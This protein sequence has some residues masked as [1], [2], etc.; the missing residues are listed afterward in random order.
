MAF[1]TGTETQTSLAVFIPQVWGQ[2]VN[3]FFKAKLACAAFFTN[4]SDEVQE[5]GNTL[6][7]PNMTEMTTNAK[8]NA[9]QVTLNSP[10]ETKIT[11]TINNWYECSFAIEDLEAAQVKRSYSTMQTYAKNA[12]YSI[13]KK[14]DIS[15]T[16]LFSTFTTSVGSSTTNLLDSDIRGA[17]ANL[18]GVDVD[19]DEC[20]WFMHP[21]VF[22]N[23]V[24]A[25]DKFSLA[26]NAP[27]QDPVGK[28]PKAYL[29]GK[30]IFLTTTIQYV[31]G[32]TGRV[33]AF[34]HPDAIHFATSPLGEGG[35]GGK[36]VGSEGIRVQSNYFPA[37]LS[38]ITTADIAY[39]SVVNR[40]YAGVA[41]LSKA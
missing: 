28:T 32:T 7:T 2:S 31:S 29:Y 41:V 22:W 11:L 38:T 18:D 27:E 19:T 8:V 6:F 26:I 12:G 4:R 40:A 24:Q 34:A 30:P 14:L 17:I 37:Y 20:A 33:N 35:S 10:T 5:G 39:G 3:D 15:M 25:L 1:P 23:Q 13:A 9:Q 21:V 36:M 16:L